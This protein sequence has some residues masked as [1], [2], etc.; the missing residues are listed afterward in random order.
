MSFHR[1]ACVFVLGLAAQT[2]VAGTWYVDDDAVNDPGP[3]S[4]FSSDPL[5]ENLLD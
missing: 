1:A 3:Y 2:A 5:E 4:P